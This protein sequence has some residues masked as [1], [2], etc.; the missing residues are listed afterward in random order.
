MSYVCKSTRLI[1]ILKDNPMS[2]QSLASDKEKGNVLNNDKYIEYLVS[3]LQVSKQ[4]ISE[5]LNL[6]N[7]TPGQLAKIIR[8]KQ[9]TSL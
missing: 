6:Y 9:E 5:T 7:V 1:R 3:T 2:N 4:E 8:I